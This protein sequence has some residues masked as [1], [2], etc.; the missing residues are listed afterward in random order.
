[1]EKTFQVAVG[2]IALSVRL[3]TTLSTGDLVCIVV[4]VDSN[5]SSPGENPERVAG[6]TPKR[7]HFI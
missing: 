7:S 3:L 4:G 5:S 6:L 2:G 1:M